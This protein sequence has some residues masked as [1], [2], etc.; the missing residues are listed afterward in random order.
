M[1]TD[2]AHNPYLIA[3]GLNKTEIPIPWLGGKRLRFAF[4]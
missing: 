2:R 4:G 1:A 3:A